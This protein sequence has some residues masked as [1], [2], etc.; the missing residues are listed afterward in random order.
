MDKILLKITGTQQD[1]V[2]K[3][4][5]ELTTVGTLRDDGS[6]YIVKYTEECEPPFSPID[7]NPEGRKLC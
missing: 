5:V 7:E 4:S 6:A 3:D 2:Q 1:G